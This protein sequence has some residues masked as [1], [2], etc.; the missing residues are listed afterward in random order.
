[1]EQINSNFYRAD[2]VRV[3]L[4]WRPPVRIP[5]AARPDFTHNLVI[6]T[7]TK[8][9]GFH[10][11]PLI[12]QMLCAV[13]TTKA[14]TKGLRGLP[15][16]KA[17]RP[18]EGEVAISKAVRHLMSAA[19]QHGF[20]PA[21]SRM[22]DQLRQMYREDLERLHDSVG[23]L[24]T[25]ASRRRCWICTDTATQWPDPRRF[26]LADNDPILPGLLWR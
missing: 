1:M 16:R 3:N 5:T 12:S 11:S 25:G 21:K 6:A 15:E 4:G 9:D 14:W 18:L 2:L 8:R 19:Y 22:P 20:N 7:G 13:C 24:R 23:A 17:L 26:L 10:L